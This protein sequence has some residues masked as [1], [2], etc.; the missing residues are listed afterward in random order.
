MMLDRFGAEIVGVVTAIIGLATIAVLI[1]QKGQ[2]TAA[3]I[4]RKSV[5]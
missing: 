3:V 1:S 2:G 4:D 5:V